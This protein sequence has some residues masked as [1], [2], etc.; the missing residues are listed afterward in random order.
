MSHRRGR[1]SW[2]LEERTSGGERIL[3]EEL[4]SVEEL[5]AQ[6]A[7]GEPVQVLDARPR[8]HISRTVD[9]MQGAIW[10]DPDRVDE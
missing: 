6:L 10:R 5:A 8:H 7:K 9:L 2:P 4:T 3:G 1:K